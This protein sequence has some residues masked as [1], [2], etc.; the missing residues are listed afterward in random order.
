M[1][2]KE[3][4]LSGIIW[5]L[6]QQF[7]T[8]GINLVV[9][10][11]MARFLMPE[12]F[13]LIGVIYIF[14]NLGIVLYEGGL[15]QSLI[16]TKE[17][18]ANDFSTVFYVNLGFSIIIYL[19]IYFAAP[20]IALFYD[21]SILTNIIRIYSLTLIISSFST[22]QNI[23]LVKELRFKTQLKISIPSLVI[24][25]TVGITM[26]IMGFGVWSLVWSSIIRSFLN[27][28]QLWFY[29]RWKPS[30]VFNMSKIKKHFDYGYK[31]TLTELLNTVFVNIYPFVIGKYFNLSSVAFYTQSDALKQVPVSNIYGAV[32]RVAF[33]V[34]ATITK[35]GELKII[36]KKL[37]Q[38][39]AFA[40]TPILLLLSLLA[41]PVIAF[42]F[43]DKWLGAVPFLKILCF[44]GIITPLSE[45]NLNVLKVKG[46]SD[47]VLK[48]GILNKVITVISII[49]SFKLGV[50]ALLWAKLLSTALCYY[51]NS[52]YTAALINY[53]LKEQ[54]KDIGPIFLIAGLSG[55]CVFIADT[56][57]SG[58]YAFDIIRI[59]LGFGLGFI[60]Y[61]ILN[62]LFN[63][64]FLYYLDLLR[65]RFKT[66]LS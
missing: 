62:Y 49:A 14:I 56:L 32:N 55:V 13:G 17:P 63:P 3:K 15:S 26:A 9:S 18:D 51:F 5:S 48:L 42:L 39:I 36:Y 66:T 44:V 33:P 59:V 58:Y 47:L 8:Q 23:I 60:V 10:V 30:L 28:V 50:I 54:V 43:T 24:G 52:I 7:S 46:R 61:F 64:D 45:Y 53:S 2:L 22:V 31:L 1:S 65:N 11:I 4:A 12:D 37:M 19:I 16:R 35:E 6:L 57:M 20:Y 34:M 25:S 38:G 27:S 29:N 21:K 40:I 41:E